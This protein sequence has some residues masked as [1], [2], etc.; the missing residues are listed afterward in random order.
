MI[1]CANMG[2]VSGVLKRGHLA[3]ECT[4]NIM[5]FNCKQQHHVSLCQFKSLE[6]SGEP[7][8]NNVPQSVAPLPTPVTLPESKVVSM[9][10]TGTNPSLNN[11]SGYQQ[12]HQPV[13]TACTTEPELDKFVC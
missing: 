13:T 10:P 6:K 9:H 3:R 8:H 1:C 2:N 12:V 4:S 7:N 5:C 11:P